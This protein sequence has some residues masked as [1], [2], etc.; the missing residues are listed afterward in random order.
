MTP[1]PVRP[2]D[3]KEIHVWTKVQPQIGLLREAYLNRFIQTLSP[4]D[5]VLDVGCGEADM[6][7]L[8]H[9]R[10]VKVLGVDVNEEMITAAKRDH[11]PV[12]Q[13]DGLEAVRAL[14]DEYNVVCMLDFVEHVPLEV[15]ME[16]LRSVAEK[17]GRTLWLQ[18]PNLDAIMGFK[19]WFHM[20]SHVTAI[21]PVVLRALLSRCGLEIVS[22]WSDYGGLPWRGFRRWITLKIINGLFG[23]PLADLFVGGGNICVVARSAGLPPSRPPVQ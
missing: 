12:Q 11:L 1:V 14:C 16:I 19:F 3:F 13:M 17:P 22:E 8:L 20:P 9:R 10:G 5:A 2:E 7:R 23:S 6:T 15:V 21:H 18:T 4:G